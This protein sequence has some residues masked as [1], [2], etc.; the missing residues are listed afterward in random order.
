VTHRGPAYVGGALAFANSW[1]TTNRVALGDQ[2][3]AS[4]QGQ[5]YAARLEGGYRFAVPAPSF[6]SP[7][8]RGRVMPLIPRARLAWAHDWVSNP[9]LNAAFESL[10]ELHRV[11]RGDPAE[12][13][14]DLGR[15][16]IV[17]HATLVAHRQVRW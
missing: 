9:A 3:T 8:K 2:L 14:I 6:P 7:R 15:R 12:F 17:L 5:S 16:A 1:F 13:G 4:F 11:R 10:H